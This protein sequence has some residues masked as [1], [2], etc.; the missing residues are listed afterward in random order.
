MTPIIAIFHEVWI[1]F[2]KNLLVMSSTFE[3]GGYYVA[4]VKGMTSY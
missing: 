1:I 4:Y 2:G 3:G